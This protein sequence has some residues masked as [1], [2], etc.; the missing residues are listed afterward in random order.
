MLFRANKAGSEL[1]STAGVTALGAGFGRRSHRV[2]GNELQAGVALIPG[3]AQWSAWFAWLCG[4]FF[5]VQLSPK[6][7]VTGAAQG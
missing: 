6:A 1:E 4:V 5:F 3:D 2:H 7:R